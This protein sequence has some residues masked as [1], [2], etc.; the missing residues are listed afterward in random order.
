MQSG[1]VMFRTHE[2]LYRFTHSEAQDHKKN[3]SRWVTLDA[4]Q[5]SDWFEAQA[6]IWQELSFPRDISPYARSI[7]HISWDAFEEWLSDLSWLDQEPQKDNAE[8]MLCPV[9]IVLEHPIILLEL[10]A[11]EYAIFIDTCFDAMCLHQRDGRN[12]TL[13]LGPAEGLVGSFMNT[14]RA[15]DLYVIKE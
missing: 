14:L 8:S 10:N 13:I 6:Q 15:R 5:L 9:V 3:Y 11:V 2:G 1:I 7:R 4:S 12:F